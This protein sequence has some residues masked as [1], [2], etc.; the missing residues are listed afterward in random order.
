MADSSEALGEEETLQRQCQTL[1]ILCP[2]TNAQDYCASR[3]FWFYCS[4]DRRLW[5]GAESLTNEQ[6]WPLAVVL[7]WTESRFSTNT[8]KTTQT[9]VRIARPRSTCLGGLRSWRVGDPGGASKP[10]AGVVLSLHSVTPSEK[11]WVFFWWSLLHGSLPGNGAKKLFVL[12]GSK[13]LGHWVGVLSRHPW[14]WI[15]KCV[16]E[17]PRSYDLARAV[18]S[19]NSFSSPISR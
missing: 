2:L 9:K 4:S 12:L 16:L 3:F 7:Q 8:K 1:W 6:K 18:R 19:V 15:S 5:P 14:C 13:K 11:S 10:P 17:H